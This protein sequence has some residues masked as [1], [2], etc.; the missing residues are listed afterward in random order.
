M[1]T[2]T[3][4]NRQ[5]LYSAIRLGPLRSSCG[6]LIS[7]STDTIVQPH[8]VTQLHTPKKKRVTYMFGSG[9]VGVWRGPFLG[10]R[11]SSVTWA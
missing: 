10:A 7:S 4:D 2:V 8:L 3:R 6:T 9:D 1:D 11:D 5:L